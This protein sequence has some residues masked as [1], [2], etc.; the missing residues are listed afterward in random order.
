MLQ[1]GLRNFLASAWSHYNGH[2]IPPKEVEMIRS[3]GGHLFI[4]SGALSAM[5][6]PPRLSAWIDR[7][8]DVA[9]LARTV[10]AD[11]VAHLDIPMERHKLASAGIT[12][13]E[14]LRITIR[15]ARAFLDADVGFAKKVYVIQGWT[16]PEYRE[17]LDTYDNLGIP[18]GGALGIGTCCMRK[19]SR[20]LWP[21]LETLRA[22][23]NG[24][25]LHSFGTGDPAKLARL[26]R[27]GID[28]VDEGLSLRAFIYSK[29][30]KVN[31]PRLLS[32]YQGHDV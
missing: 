13:R 8:A 31:L 16:L 6:S 24:R 30:P 26:A 19:E 27:I 7:Q 22:E 2:K 18:D 32:A 20:G 29:S 21:I 3:E 15:N 14:A 23:T 10:R 17:C 1:A 12:R 25:M 11:L 9:S 28:S 4:D 5:S